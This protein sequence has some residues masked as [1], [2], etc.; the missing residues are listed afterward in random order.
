MREAAQVISILKN[1]G[2]IMPHDT[3]INAIFVDVKTG[4][5]SVLVHDRGF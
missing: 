3:K 5:D 4:H 1:N 2:L